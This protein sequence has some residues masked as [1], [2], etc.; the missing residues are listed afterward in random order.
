MVILEGEQPTGYLY[1][2]DDHVVR[3]CDAYW[4][5]TVGETR[6]GCGRLGIQ[7]CA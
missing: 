1:I 6:T 7:A 5:Q 3:R 2:Y 4:G